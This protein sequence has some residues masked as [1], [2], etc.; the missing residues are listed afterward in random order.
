MRWYNK[1]NLTETDFG[2]VMYWKN[3]AENTDLSR[4]IAKTL[5]DIFM[6]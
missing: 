5:T 2:E 4:T 3:L 6:P 1:M